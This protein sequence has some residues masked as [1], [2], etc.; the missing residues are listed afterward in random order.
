MLEYHFLLA[1]YLPKIM[2]SALKGGVE[3]EPTKSFHKPAY[4]KGKRH[5]I[6]VTFSIFF[7][8]YCHGIKIKMCRF[9][10]CSKFV[11]DK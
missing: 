3:L 10:L 7:G 8:H 1:G 6:N 2:E 5:I 4:G 11:T 9:L